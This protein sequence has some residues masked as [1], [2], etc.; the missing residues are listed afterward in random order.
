MRSQGLVT[1]SRVNPWIWLHTGV[2]LF[3]PSEWQWHSI[4]LHLPLE[5]RF[6]I[7]AKSIKNVSAPAVSF[8]IFKTSEVGASLFC[9]LFHLLLF[10]RDF[11]PFS[12]YIFWVLMVFLLICMNT[13]KEYSYFYSVIFASILSQH[14]AHLLIVSL[15]ITGKTPINHFY[16]VFSQCTFSDSITKPF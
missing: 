2:L 15:S 6:W 3:R 4:P 13:Y 1:Y 12:G 16:Y 11:L 5:H 8:S 14:E 7:L 10:F 9:W